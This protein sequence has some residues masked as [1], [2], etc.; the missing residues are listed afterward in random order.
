MSRKLTISSDICIRSAEVDLDNFKAP[1][2]SEGY[3]AGFPAGVAS[4]VSKSYTTSISI[5]ADTFNGT[6]GIKYNY[7]KLIIGENRGVWTFSSRV[8]IYNFYLSKN[9]ANYVL[10]PANLTVSPGDI[11][12]VFVVKTTDSSAASFVINGNYALTTPVTPNYSG[13]TEVLN[14]GSVTFMSLWARSMYDWYQNFHDNQ[15]DS[16]SMIEWFYNIHQP[17]YLIRNLA[18]NTINATGYIWNTFGA[19]IECSY[20]IMV[21]MIGKTPQAGSAFRLGAAGRKID[22]DGYNSA[23]AISSGISNYNKGSNSEFYITF[24][25]SNIIGN[26]GNIAFSGLGGCSI[27]QNKMF[28]V[29]SYTDI[30]ILYQSFYGTINFAIKGSNNPCISTSIGGELWFD[31]TSSTQLNLNNNQFAS[32]KSNKWIF[33]VGTTTINVSNNLMTDATTGTNVILNNIR[34]RSDEQIPT[35]NITVTLTGAFMANPTGG[36]LNADWVIIAAKYVANGR[37]ATLTIN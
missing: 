14:A 29:N 27:S 13:R 22:I 21:R 2:V 9:G 20:M 7:V 6:D 35:A 8:N 28:K 11:I 34:Q 24:M 10:D 25:L 19:S 37:T 26:A 18:D 23:L 31:T 15:L 33:P 5:P 1:Y 12:E 16:P 17:H 4:V 36:Q 3:A 30:A 32:C